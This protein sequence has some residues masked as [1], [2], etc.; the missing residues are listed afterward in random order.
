MKLS[1]GVA[2]PN[3]HPLCEEEN[4]VKVYGPRGS[5]VLKV[6][7]TCLSCRPHDIDVADSVF[8]LLDDPKKGRVKMTWRFVDCRSNPP[9]TES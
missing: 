1:P 4:C 9:G 2:N 7:D 6:S 3:R 5:V 8:P